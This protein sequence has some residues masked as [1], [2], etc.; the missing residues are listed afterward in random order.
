MYFIGHMVVIRPV[1][2]IC[3]SYVEIYMYMTNILT[4]VDPRPSPG[5]YSVKDLL[6]RIYIGP[7]RLFQSVLMGDDGHYLAFF[8]SINELAKSMADDIGRDVGAWL[9]IYLLKQGWQMS[10][11]QM[12]IKK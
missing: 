3:W 2:D 7:I 6:T 4:A 11:I 8:S 5:E 1:L 12:L 10:S 9:K